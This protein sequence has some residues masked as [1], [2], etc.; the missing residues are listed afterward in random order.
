MREMIES[1]LNAEWIF[2]KTM[3]YA[4]HWYTLK[5]NWIDPKAFEQVVMFIRLNGYV[6]RY[7]GVDYISYNLNGMYYW[8]MGAPLEDTILINRA[9]IEDVESEYDEIAEAY[10]SLFTDEKSIEENKY[11]IALAGIETGDNV[12]DIGCGTGLLLEYV[13][14]DSIVYHGVDPSDGMLARFRAKYGL[15]HITYRCGF[16][17]FFPPIRYDKVVSLFGSMNY[18]SPDAISKLRDV[19]ILGGD[20]M[21]VMYKDGYDPVTY[22]KT[23]V[24]VEHH[25]FSEYTFPEHATIEEYHN[26]MI[27]R[28][29]NK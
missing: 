21:L 15:R 7:K 17:E 1:L 16:E 29:R 10:D 11:V 6:R 19:T 4:P 24:A 8:T 22:Q 3:P 20:I 5:R 18:V 12:L 13:D 26:Y 25:L 9:F 27:V 2:A 14:G 28:W 23:G